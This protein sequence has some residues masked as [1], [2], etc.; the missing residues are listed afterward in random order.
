MSNAFNAQQSMSRAQTLSAFMRGVYGWMSAGLALTAVVAV[1]VASSPAML[2]L[3]FNPM[4]L[5]VLVLAEL[6]LVLMLSARINRMSPGAATGMFLGYSALNGLTLS[7]IF[8]TYTATSI[9]SAFAVSAGMFMAMSLY[10]L[11][12]KRDLTGLG[13]FLFMGLIGIFI[14]MLVNIFLHSSMMAF[15]IDC[16]GVLIFT[17]LTAYDTQ[18]LK[19]M[20]DH[21]PMGDSAALRRG[22]IMG[23]LVLYLDFINLF[24]FLLRIFGGN[25]E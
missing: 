9:A 24:L 7:G 2:K 18:R 17:G 5:I 16:I 21:A 13:S 22:S 10:G 23:A 6:G 3:V 8:I 20:G 14:A 25:R 19:D 11:V 15:I 1:S 12:T 4:A